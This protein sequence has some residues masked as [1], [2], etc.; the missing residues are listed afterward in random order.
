MP[1]FTKLDRSL[2]DQPVRTLFFLGLAWGFLAL[3]PL[4]ASFSAPQE[5][6]FQVQAG[7]FNYS[8]SQLHVNPGDR[9]T[10]ELASQDVVHGI[11]IDGY[12]LEVHAD[13][14]QPARL[15]FVAV[16]PGSFRF[17]CSVTCG[18]LHPFMIGQL[19]VGVNWLFWKALASAVLAVLAG[20]WRMLS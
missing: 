14:G 19:K 8:P 18:A 10:I 6:F 2:K 15:S 16:K 7:S 13:P 11:Y 9:V 17:R 4:P 1:A 12:D 20:F 3:V 5:R